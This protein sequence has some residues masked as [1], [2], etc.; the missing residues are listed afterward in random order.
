M[1]L[2]KTIVSVIIKKPSLFVFVF[3]V[4]FSFDR[5]NRWVNFDKDNFPL[6]HDVDQFYSYLPAA[7]I[8]HDL[9]FNFS[10]N[11]WAVKA[12]NGNKIA[13][14]TYGMAAMYSPFFVIGHIY[15]G[16]NGYKQDGYSLPYKW[17]LHFGTFFYVLLGLWFC[18]KNLLSFFNE[19]VTALTLLGI[20][21]GTNL[22]YYTFGWGEMSHS[23]LFFV[24]SAAIY[25]FLKWNEHKQIKYF[26][27]FCFLAGFATLIRPTDI[28]I[29]LLPLLFNITQWSDLKRRLLEFKAL[30]LKLF[31]GFIIFIVPVFFQLLYWKLYSGNWFV[32]TY[33][34]GERFF[35][36]DPQVINFLF[37]FRKGWFIYTPLMFLLLFGIPFLLKQTKS[38]FIFM[39]VYFMANVYLLSSWWDWGFGGSFGCRA[40]IQHYSVFMFGLAAFFNNMFSLC[41]SRKII[42]YSIKL[43]GFVFVMAIIKLNYNQSWQY[44]YSL[45]HPS[46]MTKEAYFFVFNK[47]KF[48]TEELET[49]KASVKAPDYP[50]MLSGKRD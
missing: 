23:Y 16:A 37:S 42:N 47:E 24:L 29:L 11:Y 34:A 40:I 6:V 2:L 32:F 5:Y 50:A 12:E 45:I 15:A 35:F 21:L 22:F 18:R 48:T 19:L 8:H 20:F 49:Y 25:V 13:R 38:I 41:N 17:S 36:N 46:G 9:T 7:F 4:V 31:I 39:L 33:G 28:V 44:K 3:F 30:G 27:R 26:Y 43:T 10:N 14:T 1:N